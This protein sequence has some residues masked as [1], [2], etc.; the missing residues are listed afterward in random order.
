MGVAGEGT[1]WGVP[2]DRPVTLS[3]GHF[4]L[5]GLSEDRLFP[6]KPF[7]G[8]PRCSAQRQPNRKRLLALPPAPHLLN[9]GCRE[10]GAHDPAL[11]P[12]ITHSRQALFPVFR[13]H[14][15]SA[16]IPQDAPWPPPAPWAQGLAALPLGSAE[17]LRLQ[18]AIEAW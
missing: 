8:G 11:L 7:R 5:A 2:W 9:S 18:E 3:E 15:L 17:L 10:E 13:L 16:G 12:H 6:L 1:M 4:R 14:I